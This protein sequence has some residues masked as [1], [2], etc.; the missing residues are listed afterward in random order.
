MTTQTSPLLLVCDLRVHFFP[1]A[2]GPTN[3]C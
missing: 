3:G 2:I 1:A